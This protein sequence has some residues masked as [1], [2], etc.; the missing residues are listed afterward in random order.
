LGWE[1]EGFRTKA[2]EN[3]G[4]AEPEFCAVHFPCL[5]EGEEEEECGEG[6]G[7][8]EVGDVGPE[9]DFSQVFFELGHDVREI[10]CD[11]EV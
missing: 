6:Y 5:C 9:V 7:S 3:E 8:R 11:E 2:A 10:V 4:D 1:G